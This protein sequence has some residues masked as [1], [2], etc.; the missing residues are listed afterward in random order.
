MGR[1]HDTPLVRRGL[2]AALVAVVAAV[3]LVVVP[4]TLAGARAAFSATT[5]NTGDMLSAATLLPPSGLAVTQS[6]TTAPA[7]THR[8]LSGGSGTGSLTLAAPAGTTTGDVLVAH[9]AYRDVP[10]AIT[11]PSG[12]TR[13]LE[14]TTGPVTSAIYW[15]P[16]TSA[17]PTAVFT[18]P[19]GSTGPIGGGMVAL[20]GA[21]VTAPVA[22]GAV[23]TGTTATTAA[24]TTTGTTVEALYFFTKDQDQLPT[25]AG[26]TQVGAGL[27]GTAP[28]TEGL[29][30]AEETVPGPGALPTRTSTSTS[31]TSSAWIAQT[32]VLG[33]APGTPTANLS[34]TASPST[35]ASGYELTRAVGGTTQVT[36]TVAG[37]ATTSTTDG[38]LV[39]GTSYTFGLTAAKGTWRSSP[40]S[41]PLAASCP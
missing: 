36:S 10:E 30:G 26:T 4:A 31:G 40:V 37:A 8:T 9:V 18:R 5:G 27:L 3:G 34:W 33:R 35:W 41:V 15:K 32:L 1:R 6:C 25:P 20:V 39:S 38:P 12:W 24:A 19:A 2:E 29:T 13:L 21:A 14:D 28:A 22:S 7:I 23:G 16:A 11:A 17:E